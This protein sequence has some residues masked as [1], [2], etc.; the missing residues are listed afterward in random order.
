[1]A[2][3]VK[4]DNITDVLGFVYDADTLP[5]A[6][7][8]FKDGGVGISVHALREGNEGLLKKVLFDKAGMDPEKPL[9]GKGYRFHE[10]ARRVLE[11]SLCHGSYY[12]EDSN[13]EKRFRDIEEWAVKSHDMCA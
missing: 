12:H 2:T 11:T 8:V 3:T 13:D 7:L 10:E 6:I 9:D 4:L 1:M 5:T